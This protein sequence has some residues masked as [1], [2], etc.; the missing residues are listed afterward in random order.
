MHRRTMRPIRA[1]LAALG[2]SLALTAPVS[3]FA[4]ANIASYTSSRMG[5]AIA[6][7]YIVTLKSDV[8]N[9]AVTAADMVSSLGGTLHHTYNTALKGFSATLPDAA[10]AA[11]RNNPAVAAI[12]ADRVAAAFPAETPSP[13][14]QPNATWGIDRIDQRSLPL[15][16]SYN[17]QYLGTGVTVFI[18]DTG[19]RLDHTEYTGRVSLPGY[20]AIG[21]GNGVNDCNGH[22]THVAGTVGGTTYGVAKGVS[23]TPVR[24]LGCDG[25]G[26]NSGVIAGIDFV[27]QSSRRPAVANM[28]LGGGASDAIDAA[29][30]GAINAG[31]TMVV[32]AG[33]SNDNACNYSPARAPNA[34]TV[35]ATTNTDARASYSNYGTCLDIFAPGSGI[36][37]AW[38]T[39]PTATNTLNGTSMA[40]PHVAGVAALTLAANPT[41]TPAA[42]T[43]TILNN[44]TQGV[45]TNPG[46]GSPNKLL[47]SPPGG[48]GGGGGGVQPPSPRSVAVAALVGSSKAGVGIGAGGNGWSA[49]VTVTVRDTANNALVP[50]A[51]VTGKFLGVVDSTYCLTDVTGSCKLYSPIFGNSFPSTIFSVSNITG[52]LMTY[53]NPTFFITPSIN[54]SKPLAP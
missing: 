43:T 45:V 15:S 38:Y 6:G 53:D 30:Q 22:G 24:V 52:N 40:T 46:T 39:S 47:Y 32:A 49:T 10:V 14:T 29:V 28:S 31:V 2:C 21:D 35:G 5:Q 33:N 36:T 54:I 19:M 20:D 51:K 4:D 16:A 18:I 25:Y 44:A 9:V 37:S 8:A 42:V 50:F 17:Y 23:L 48:G 12:E 41:A 3:A 34:I 13:R 1:A 26:T 27:A 7:R 11:L